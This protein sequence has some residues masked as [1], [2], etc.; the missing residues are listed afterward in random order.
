MKLVVGLGNPGKEYLNS[1]HNVGFWLA[2]TLDGKLGAGQFRPLTRFKAEAAVGDKLLIAKPQTM[3]N[4][5]G[6]A[7]AALVKFYKLNLADVYV[8]HDDLDIRL[9]KF[10]LQFGRGPKVHRGL[11]S[12]YAK[13]GTKNFWHVRIGTDNRVNNVN[14]KITGEEYVLAK[15]SAEERA[16][17]EPVIR[18]AAQR[19]SEELFEE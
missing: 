10:K 1:R 16:I 15:F 8:A 13:L 5:S 2:E 3:M 7:V 18:E 4:G 6:E 11:Q 14:N 9:G 19:L 17:I 12:I